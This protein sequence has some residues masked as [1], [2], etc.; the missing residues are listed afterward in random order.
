MFDEIICIGTSFTYGH[1]LHPRHD[2]HIL[3]WYK[4]NKDISLDIDKH[5]YPSILSTLTNTPVRNYGWCGSSLDYVVR[6]TDE[7]FYEEDLSNKLLI[8]E[9]SNWGRSELYSTKLGQ[10]IIANW[11]PEDGDDTKNGYATM[12]TVD[13]TKEYENTTEIYWDFSEEIKIYNKFLNS[14]QDEQLELIRKDR[15]FVNLLYKLYYHNIDF[16]VLPLQKFFTDDIINDKIVK[17]RNINISQTGDGMYGFISEKK[18][19]IMDDT[20]GEIQEGH[21]SPD[22]YREIANKVYETII[23]Y[24]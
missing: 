19:R 4:E 8:L 9:Y 2:K 13:Y 17:K 22:G 1:G 23:N 21:P 15:V 24:E 18:L 6:K 11:G 12:L 5:S 7:L 20:N 16:L 3:E 14:F 10:Y